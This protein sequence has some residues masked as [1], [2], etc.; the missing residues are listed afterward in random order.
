V[1]PKAAGDAIVE[2]LRRRAPE[3]DISALRAAVARDVAAGN[4]AASALGARMDGLLRSLG[5]GK[6]R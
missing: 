5:T 6:E 4:G 1:P 2:L 3:S